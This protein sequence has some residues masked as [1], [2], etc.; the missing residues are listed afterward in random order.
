MPLDWESI[1][2]TPRP[3]VGP[4]KGKDGWALHGQNLKGEKFYA[5]INHWAESDLDEMGT[6]TAYSCG[7][8]DL[9][10]AVRVLAHLADGG[11]AL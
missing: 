11:E 7:Q 6:K 5:G 8:V 10:N 1:R 3:E 9:L 4:D 2:L